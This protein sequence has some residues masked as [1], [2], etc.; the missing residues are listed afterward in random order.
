MVR[1]FRNLLLVGLLGLSLIALSVQT[2]KG[3]DP[4]WRRFQSSRAYSNSNGYDANPAP[5]VPGQTAGNGTYQSF[6]ADSRVTAAPVLQL[7]YYLDAGYYHYYYA[8][9]RAAA[10]PAP[11]APLPAPKQTVK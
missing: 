10:P 5:V 6:S 11:G 9:P 1:A 8:P 4:T 2:A 3:G 7:Y